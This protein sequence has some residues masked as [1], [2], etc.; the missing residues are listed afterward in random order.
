[1]SVIVCKSC[2]GRFR[3]TATPEQDRLACPRCGV[4]LRTSSSGRVTT[5]S[6]PT[7]NVTAEGG[8]RMSGIVTRR[9]SNARP[10]VVATVCVLIIALG[11][12][13]VLQN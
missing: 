3:L 10:I 8:L 2:G 5:K 13:F 11:A 6:Q 12:F 1:M 9:K 4:N 7:A